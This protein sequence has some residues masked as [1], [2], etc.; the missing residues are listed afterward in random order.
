MLL[1]AVHVAVARIA[2]HDPA[3]HHDLDRERRRIGK[4]LDF[5]RRSF[6]QLRD[7]MGRQRFRCT[8]RLITGFIVEE[9]IERQRRR[10]GVLAP[11]N[12]RDVYELQRSVL[13]AGG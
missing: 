8:R 3:R 10:P 11:N 1:R 12:F 4:D 6:V 7:R 2:G 5:F 13:R 9:E